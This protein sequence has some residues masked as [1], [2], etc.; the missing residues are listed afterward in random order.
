MSWIS[1]TDE[2]AALAWM[3]DNDVAGPVNLVA[4]GAV[5]NSE[6]GRTLGKVLRRPVL[7][8]IPPLGPTLLYGRRLVREL[9]LASTLV[10]PGVLGSSGFQFA[11]PSLNE[12]L[13]E[14]IRG[15]AA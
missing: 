1:L 5:T 15:S 12:A 3:I 13:V 6:F 7:L 8:P 11:H 2:V 9:M 4:P 14:T 10:L